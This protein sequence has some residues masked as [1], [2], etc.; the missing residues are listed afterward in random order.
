MPSVRIASKIAEKNS[1]IVKEF[2]TKLAEINFEN[3]EVKNKKL[4]AT[5]PKVEKI[6]AKATQLKTELIN[7]EE[8]V[9]L[10]P[11]KVEYSLPTNLIALM[12]SFDFDQKVMV[13]E[14]KVEE[15]K[16]EKVED[17]ISTVLAST[18]VSDEEPVFFEYPAEASVKETKVTETSKVEVQNKLVNQKPQYTKEDFEKMADEFIAFDYSDTNGSQASEKITTFNVASP[19]KTNTKKAGSKKVSAKVAAVASTSKMTTQKVNSQK[20]ELNKEQNLLTTQKKNILAS[21]MS[22]QATGT[23]LRK[24]HNVKNFEVRFQDDL[25]EIYEDYGSGEVQI[26]SRVNKVMNRSMVLLKRGYAPT[27]TDLI[28]ENNSKVTLP[29]IEEEVF[30]ELLDKNEGYA[31]RGALLVEFD[32]ET[33]TVLLDTEYAEEIS[34]DQNLKATSSEDY[35]YKLFVGLPA[36]NVYLI[37]KKFDGSEVSK[38]VHIHE[39]EITFEANIYENVKHQSVS[40]YEEGLLSKELSPLIVSGEQVRIFATEKTSQKLSQNTYKLNQKMTLLGG[41]QYLEVNHLDEPVFVGYRDNA[42]IILPSE[43]FISFV[44]SKFE[45]R[46]LGNRCI[47]QVNIDAP[48]ANFSI[49][50]ESVAN[51]LVTSSQ[52]LDQDGKFYDSVGPKSNKII[53]LGENFGSIDQS[54]DGKVNIKIDYLD[55][56]TRFLS[57]YCSP[58]TYLVEQL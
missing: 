35:R 21:I 17:K 34:L 3:V 29:L 27:N 53:I 51:G 45:D 55:G 40:L 41:R 36:G 20:E 47:I 25:N 9:K 2:E 11:V 18:T 14:V 22:I 5:K 26:A 39:R 13:A 30:N 48:V 19:V 58:N 57:S 6:A 8:P 44:L 56:S 33:E 46:K 7:F 31:A 23:N 49:A 15:S 43:N 16:E 50:S 12:P 10:S 54:Q 38:I 28:V 1:S 42:K 37:Y 32:D 4:V 52:V 24:V